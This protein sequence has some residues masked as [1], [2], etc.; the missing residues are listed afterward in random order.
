MYL[1]PVFDNEDLKAKKLSKN[2][3]T[4]Q[5]LQNAMLRLIFGFQIKQRVN[6][7]R[8]REKIKMFSVNQM[9]VYHTILEAYNVV[10][11][12]SSQKIKLKWENKHETNYFFRSEAKNDKRVPKKT[13]ITNF[14][15]FGAK[16][17]N[18]V[19]SDIKKAENSNIFKE[20]IKSEMLVL[21]EQ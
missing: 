13:K 17:Y 18:L 7:Q 4:L 12:S 6:M 11:N 8:L 3:S 20:Q 1:N 5:T 14:S 9:C 21:D 2:A 16:L 10:K 15:Y 19:P